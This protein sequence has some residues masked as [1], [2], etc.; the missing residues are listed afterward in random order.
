MELG[1]EV[2]SA[3]HASLV[4]HE[5]RTVAVVHCPPRASETWLREDDAEHFYIRASNATEELT[6]RSLIGYIREHWAE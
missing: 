3:V 1:R 2:W 4:R 5:Q 6:G